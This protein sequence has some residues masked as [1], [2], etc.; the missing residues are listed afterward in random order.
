MKVDVIGLVLSGSCFL[1]CL[2]LP[3]ALVAA[4]S[5][6]VWLGETETSVHW[7]LFVV[8][9]LV[10][11]WALLTGLRRHGAWLVVAVGAV[12]LVV[13]GVA[14]AHL[15]GASMEVAL[16]LTGA[17]IVALAHLVNLRLTLGAARAVDGEGCQR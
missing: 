13:M 5:L 9:L 7:L 2:L 3:V 1:H 6:A 12:G 11:G 15:F 4:P 8:A 17:S 14:A 16:T 10:S